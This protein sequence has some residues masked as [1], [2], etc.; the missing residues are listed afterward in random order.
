[1]TQINRIFSLILALVLHQELMFFLLSACID[2]LLPTPKVV[3]NVI[4]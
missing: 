3:T 1:M 4:Q 2:E